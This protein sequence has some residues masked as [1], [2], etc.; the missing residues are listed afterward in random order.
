M[1]ISSLC[2]IFSLFLPIALLKFIDRLN[3]Q[4]PLHPHQCYLLE[5]LH[6]SASSSQES[7]FQFDSTIRRSD[8]RWRPSTTMRRRAPPTRVTY[9]VFDCLKQFERHPAR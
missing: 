7:D 5:L 8:L 9:M 2:Y 6:N 4:I 3:Q 1:S